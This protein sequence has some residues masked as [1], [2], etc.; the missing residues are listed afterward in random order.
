[1]AREETVLFEVEHNEERIKDVIER[2]ATNVSECD[3][4]IVVTNRRVVL[5]TDVD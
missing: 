5:L 1:M 3:P 4:L 2:T